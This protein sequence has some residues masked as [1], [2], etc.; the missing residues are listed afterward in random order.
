M[1][2][3]GSTGKLVGAYAP[4]MNFGTGNFTIEMWIYFNVALSSQT[5][6]AGI[7]TYRS[8][9]LENTS[10]NLRCLTTN[11]IAIQLG[12]TSSSFAWTPSA[13]T[14]YHLALSRSGSN[15]YMFVNGTQQGSTATNSGNVAFETGYVFTVGGNP[16][17]SVFLN[18][19]IDDLRITKGYARYTSNFTA[20]TA[21]FPNN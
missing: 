16:A 15:L 9:S 19:Y 5:N 12:G 8:A 4:W 13:T 2:F 11:N 6:N 1:Y 20:P 7:V 18:G 14:W 21:A 17:A 3:D 10:L